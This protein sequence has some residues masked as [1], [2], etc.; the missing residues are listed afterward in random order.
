[1]EKRALLLSICTLLSS[2]VQGSQWWDNYEN[3]IKDYI[4]QFGPMGFDR[5]IMQIKDPQ[6]S[7]FICPDMEPSETVPISV[8][9]LKPADIKIVAALGDS[10]TTAIGA[11]ATNVLQ[12]PIEYRHVSWSI[13][14]Y[15]TLSAVITLPNILKIFNPNITGYSKRKTFH[16]IPPTLEQTGFNFAVTG[17]NTHQLPNQARRLV[18]TMKTF[19]GINFTE[20]WKLVTVFIGVND[21]CDYCK[22]KDLFSPHSFVYNVTVALDILSDE[23]PRTIVNLVQ[24]LPIEGLRLVNDGSF[25][26]FLQRKFC[27][28]LVNPTPDSAELKELRRINKEFQMK[29]EEL[30]ASGR[31]DDKE[32]FTVILQPF[33]KTATPPL[34]EAGEIDYS[35][36][37][38]D[39]FHFTIKGHKEMAKA[40]W[41][42]M[43][44]PEGQKVEIYSVSKPVQLICPTKECPYIYTRWNS[45]ASL[46]PPS[47]SVSAAWAQIDVSVFT[48]P[49][50]LFVNF[51]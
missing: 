12:L 51:S 41:N 6:D 37:S 45:V 20:D 25:G 1:M 21:L 34:D 50:V 23:M 22:D 4:S 28:C 13:G 36:F 31:F 26:C 2:Y 43:L 30:V 17:A 9:T 15:G 35:F 14:G 47:T 39:C 3:G 44:Q 48:L 19:P 18:D 5:N 7:P 49:L 29:L 27:P 10:L 38:P 40:L 33:L 32:D 42:N 16:Q 8:H 24:L 11:N 46:P